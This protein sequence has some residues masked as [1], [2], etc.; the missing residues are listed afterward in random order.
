MGSGCFVQR[1]SVVLAVFCANMFFALSAE[2]VTPYRAAVAMKG[3]DQ[4]KARSSS[5]THFDE[6]PAV[7]VS[8]RI[9]NLGF[10][11]ARFTTR[12]NK[13]WVS[14][15]EQNGQQVRDSVEPV[16]LRGRVAV[17]GGTPRHGRR[18]Y[19]TAAS[20]IKNQ[21]KVTFPGRATGTKQKR[22]RIY[23]IK[24]SLDG[25]VKVTARVSSVPAS[26]FHRGACGAAVGV[27]SSSEGDDDE[28]STI[29][30]I[31]TGDATPDPADGDTTLARVITI[32]TDAD[33][34]WFAKYGDS[35]NAVIAS[36][37]NTAEA[38]YHGQLGLRFR[39]VKQHVY[40]SGS[41]YTSTDSGTLLKQFT[42][43][44]A[45]PGNL[46]TGAASFNDEVDLKHL[47]TGKDI[48]GSVI[49]IAYIGTVCAAPSLAFGVTQNYLEVA[50][51]GI[52]A[53]ELGHNFGAF[54]DLSDRSGLMYPSISIPPAQRFS[55]VSLQEVQKHLA[56][57]GNCISTESM[58]PRSPVPGEPTYPVP[59][60]LTPSTSPA[61]ITL[62]R[63]RRGTRRDPLVRLSGRVL[64]AE[65]TPVG[66]VSL[67]LYVSDTKVATVITDD[68]GAFEFLVKFSMPKGQMSYAYVETADGNVSSKFLWVK[69]TLPAVRESRRRGR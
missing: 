58:A 37:I 11:D 39:I 16:L 63:Q 44:S 29:Q 65:G 9:K 43:N 28:S 27:A 49:G 56:S 17:G 66:A 40:T 1:F 19:P 10:F 64:T 50:N 48:D 60:N 69:P 5:T 32:S 22:Q 52:F 42:Q 41:P 21:L 2:A 3:L 38:L 59:P 20:I 30:P 7:K 8:G 68:S 26:A 13:T 4:A 35:S 67:G 62:H 31:P 33:A 55:D 18:V 23:T 6:I 45:N 53:H 57:N 36:I 34:E 61:T 25:T 12:R 51:P 54:H 46:G 15:V 24:I 47:F 14:T